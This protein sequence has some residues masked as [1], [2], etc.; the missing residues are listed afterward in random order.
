MNFDSEVIDI[1]KFYTSPYTIFLNLITLR[2][3]GYL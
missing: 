1:A 2:G 3:G